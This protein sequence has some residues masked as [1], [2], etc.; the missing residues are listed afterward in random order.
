MGELQNAVS[1]ADRLL[2]IDTLP[3]AAD[4]DRRSRSRERDR[5]R[6]LEDGAARGGAPQTYESIETK[7]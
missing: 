1:I 4:G 3:A 6:G 5:P 7:I 2:A